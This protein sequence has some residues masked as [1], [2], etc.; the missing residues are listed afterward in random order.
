MSFVY[1][2]NSIITIQSNKT[3]RHYTYRIT[4]SKKQDDIFYVSVLSRFDNESNDSYKFL[5]C[6]VLNQGFFWSN[7]SKISK[8]AASY[9]AAEWFFGS[10]S[11]TEHYSKLGAK[12]FR[13]SY[14][15]HCGKKI[16]HPESLKT[17]YGRSCLSWAIKNG[18][19]QLNNDPIDIKLSQ[20]TAEK[21]I[22]ST[23][24]ENKII[25]TSTQTQ[26]IQLNLFE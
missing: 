3:N 26:S 23:I 20:E 24:Q 12:V 15:S 13:E 21:L 4:R 8:T 25:I 5:G 2:G 9:I 18:L 17:G 22:E 16:T 11:N 1:G 7:R 10:V 19:I 14:C 6:W